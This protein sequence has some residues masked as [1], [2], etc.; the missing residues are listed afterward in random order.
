VRVFTESAY[1]SCDCA[2]QSLEQI[3][4]G[5]PG[6]PGAMP[7]IVRAAPE[8]VNDEP[9]ARELRAFVAAVR[10]GAPFEV[11]GEEGRRALAV[12]LAVAERI[13]ESRVEVSR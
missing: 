13:E 1:L 12:A 2:D 8:I 11:G 6:E 5:S 3:T 4:L 9:L 7:T 10:G